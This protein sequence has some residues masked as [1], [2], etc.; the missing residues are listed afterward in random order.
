MDKR[1]TRGLRQK[2]FNKATKEIVILLIMIRIMIIINM[3]NQLYTTQFLP[4][5]ENQF[6]ASPEQ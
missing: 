5:L 3:Q 1:E 2:Q 4:P 6:A